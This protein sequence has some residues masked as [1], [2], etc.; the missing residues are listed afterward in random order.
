[1]MV[2]KISLPTLNV[3]L[4]EGARMPEKAHD[5]DAGYDLF[6]RERKILLPKCSR[7]F[8]TGVHIQIPFGIDGVLYSKSGLNNR[9]KITSTGLIDSGYTGS[10]A[11]RLYNH[12]WLPRLIKKGEKITQI[13]FRE[14]KSYMLEAVDHLEETER[15]SNGF[16]STGR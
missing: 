11:A 9:R 16:G 14:N 15:G 1:M 7:N 3:V 6:S 12:S 13:V 5:A 10:I 4:D 8:D 2:I